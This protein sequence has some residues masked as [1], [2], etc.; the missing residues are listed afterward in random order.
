MIRPSAMIAM[1]EIVSSASI[2][3]VASRMSR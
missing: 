2:S 1:T 3:R